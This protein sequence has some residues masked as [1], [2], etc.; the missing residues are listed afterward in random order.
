MLC[1]CF[2]VVSLLHVISHMFIVH[3]VSLSCVAVATLFICYSVTSGLG[4]GWVGN[5][6]PEKFS[7]SC[8]YP[9][10]CHS[11]PFSVIGRWL[12]STSVD[13]NLWV[14]V[15]KPSSLVSHL[16]MIFLFHSLHTSI[17]GVFCIASMR[18]HDLHE[19]C[20]LCFIQKG[21]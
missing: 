10:R 6:F 21:V 20:P 15:W 12:S 17:S 4:S 18:I 14:P 13:V 3:E 7:G 16:S 8:F 2:C 1:R 19:D 5:L 9:P 11:L